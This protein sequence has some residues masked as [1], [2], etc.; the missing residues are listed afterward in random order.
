[1]SD[2]FVTGFTSVSA[3]VGIDKSYVIFDA[4]PRNVSE[5]D[6]ADAYPSGVGVYDKY[7]F[8]KE[9][10]KGAS[11]LKYTGEETPCY[12]LEF[13]SESDH[14]KALIENGF[15]CN[16]G[17]NGRSESKI[18]VGHMGWMQY[19]EIMRAVKDYVYVSYD[20][21]VEDEK[22]R[23]ITLTV[24]PMY[25]Y[26]DAWK[27][28]PQ[29]NSAIFD[30]FD[31]TQKN[32]WISRSVKIRNIAD[33][34][35]TVSQW[36]QGDIFFQV[37]G[38]DDAALTVK[39]RNF[40]LEVKESDRE[41]INN[42]LSTV[43]NIDN[44]KNFTTY[45][46]SDT[47]SLPDLPKDSG[48]KN[49][50]FAILTAFDAGSEYAGISLIN[51]VLPASAHGILSVPPSAKSGST[52]SVI[53]SPEIGFELSSVTV[54]AAGGSAVSVD[55]NHYG[56]GATFVMPDKEVSVSAYFEL[57]DIKE[58]N[59]YVI[60][61]SVPEK[62]DSAYSPIIEK[63]TEKGAGSIENDGELTFWRADFSKEGTV[64]FPNTANGNMLYNNPDVI[65][66]L[67]EY[68]HFE[69]DVRVNT[70]LNLK[71]K[72][73]F[74]IAPVSAYTTGKFS[75]E[76]CNFEYVDCWRS[77]YETNKW[78]T[79]D[80]KGLTFT[81]NTSPLGWQGDILINLQMSEGKVMS[82]GN[83]SV[84]IRRLRLTLDEADR[85]AVDSALASIGISDGFNRLTS[86]NKSS[87]YSTSADFGDINGDSLI[88]VRD[89]VRIAKKAADSAV[90]A[91][92]K[93]ADYNS[94]NVIDSY[95]LAAF[96]KQLLGSI[97]LRPVC[98]HPGVAEMDADYSFYAADT[99]YIPEE[100]LTLSASDERVTLN[101][102]RV[103]VPYEVRK[104]GTLTLTVQ[105]SRSGKTGSYT[106]SFIGFSEQPAFNDDF[107]T[108][109]TDVWKQCRDNDGNLYK[110]GTVSDG[111]LIFTIEKE[112]EPRC[113]LS[114]EGSFSQAYGCFSAVMEMPKIGSGNA[115]FFM[116]GNNYKHNPLT[117][118][119][120]WAGSYGEI[121]VVE[122]YPDWGDDYAGTV[123]W[124][125]WNPEHYN[126]SG[127]EH[128][129]VPNIKDGFHTY[130]VVWTEN[131][132]YWYYDKTLTRV[133]NGPGVTDGSGPMNLLL[134]LWPVYEDFWNTTYDATEFPYE[135]KFD[136]VTVW[137]LK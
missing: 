71:L 54:T 90:S 128:I 52:V 61:E 55:Y 115:S 93:A 58:R 23:D 74:I 109:D 83:V 6:G 119:D 16:D 20:I 110:S 68:I 106:M 50:Y 123:H 53:A 27:N 82:N 31:V 21:Y 19:P 48:G 30:S 129:K 126:S 101:G 64:V 125:L 132:I 112:G 12:V 113:L 49:D 118:P 89:L 59:R 57:E 5:T 65:K 17:E 66:K 134:Q 13:D 121:D 97:T 88:D 73:T 77:G 40:R 107:D 87:A 1:M 24:S 116:T 34:Q 14:D 114:T 94:D 28:D 120:I 39:I 72:P 135:A 104:G 26:L 45:F 43:E 86:G 76:I 131:A 95:D 15:M 102:M 75:Y 98:E 22:E 38:L 11:S 136:R 80:E 79:Y 9:R 36:T 4:N 2:L 100:Y 46:W 62:A 47:E 99:D 70:G 63:F 37:A 35:T 117:A 44:K 3:E 51:N 69:C 32:E 67:A 8:A 84:D 91:V 111:K 56:N 92:Y 127:N 29:S 105:D 122:Y 130:S 60:Y 25:W 137:S 103:T 41:N 42:A 96:R 78:I 7:C 124:Y 133:Y 85:A 10:V 108:L 33:A 18:A 81:S